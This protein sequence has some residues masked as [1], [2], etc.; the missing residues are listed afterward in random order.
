MPWYP[1]S[2]KVKY[3][4]I[5]V[6]KLDMPKP[7]SWENYKERIEYFTERLKDRENWWFYNRMGYAYWNM[8]EYRKSA[9]NFLKADKTSP[10]WAQK[11]YAAWVFNYE[12]KYVKAFQ[13]YEK[14]LKLAK[15]SSIGKER[16][17][18]DYTFYI[19][20]CKDEAIRESNKKKSFRSS[21]VAAKNEG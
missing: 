14:A 5:Q 6:K 18:L 8:K 2:G 15:H 21:K 4:N 12:G 13:L 11:F 3:S 16:I 7:P 19:S 9:D 1:I 20:T 10:S 17:T